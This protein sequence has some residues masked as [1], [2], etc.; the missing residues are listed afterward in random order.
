MVQM[1]D[2]KVY[3]ETVKAKGHLVVYFHSYDLHLLKDLAKEYKNFAKTERF[4]IQFCIVDIDENEES[5]KELG[6]KA[7]P[8]FIIYKDGAIVEK[9]EGE[10]YWTKIKD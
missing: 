8:C 3:D 1:R 6:I 9:I 10:T 2:K 5:V 4:D 7:A